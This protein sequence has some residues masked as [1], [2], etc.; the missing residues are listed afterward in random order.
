MHDPRVDPW[1]R[2]ANRRTILRGS[3][4]ASAIALGGLSRWDAARAQAGTPTATDPLPSWN[5]GSVKRELIDFTL[6]TIDPASEDYLPVGRRIATFDVDGTLFTEYP[7]SAGWAF[8]I[9]ATRTRAAVDPTYA[10]NAIVQDALNGAFDDPAD[11]D[12]DKY[13]Q[14]VDMTGAPSPVE[15]VT[16]SARTFLTTAVH[17]ITGNRWIDQFYQPMR[18]LVMLLA[19]SGYTVFCVSGSGVEFLRAFIPAA[20]GIPIWRIIGTTNEY[21]YTSTGGAGDVIETDVPLIVDVGDNKA[22][23]IMWHIGERPVLTI[24]NSDG[25]LEM[26]E[27]V[28]GANPDLA[29]LIHHTDAD[30]E[31]QYDREYLWSPLVKGLEA[32]PAIPL[33]DMKTDWATVWSTD[34]PVDL[35]VEM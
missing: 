20:L 18:E 31:F 15:Q 9:E 24:G 10:K 22:I 28:R 7:A 34:A 11:I 33:I 1:L 2:R 6:R 12:F 3:L 14:L 30:R 32:N 17:P 4:G 21:Q 26:V 35:N 5:E 13:Y 23:S 16:E 19:Q 29:Y 27:F 8:V 25:D